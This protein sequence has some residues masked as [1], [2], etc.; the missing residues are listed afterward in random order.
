M[1]LEINSFH[2]LGCF[3]YVSYEVY[4]SIATYNLFLTT[5]EINRVNQEKIEFPSVT[6][7]NFNRYG[8]I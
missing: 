7:C 4:R 1:Y 2:V 8:I 5:T 6:I 3:A